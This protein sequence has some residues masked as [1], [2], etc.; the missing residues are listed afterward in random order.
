MNILLIHA[1]ENPDSFCSALATTAKE[2]FE[3]KGHTVTISDL[4]AK[5]FNPV[6]SKH[7]FTNASDAAYY[8][9]A[10]E[11]FHAS[12]SNSFSKELQEEMDA[13]ANAEVLILNFPLWWF[14][15][16]AILKGWIDRVLA[17]GFAYGGEYGMYQD[18]RFKEKK[19]FLS[20]TTGT[21]AAAYSLTGFHKREMN[22]LL[23]NMQEGMLGLI[24]FEVLPPFIGYGVSRI[25]QEER[26]AILTKYK[27]YLDEQF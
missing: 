13:L 2:W 4:Y 21:P 20:F 25:S 15:L 7:D 22:D 11:Q 9:Y 5:G 19:A 18:G 1:H 27:Q 12:K 14:G 16:P 6:G 8:K 17:Y 3:A 10:L 26:T 24:G 23:R